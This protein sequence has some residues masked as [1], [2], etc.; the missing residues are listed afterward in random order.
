[1]EM[2]ANQYRIDGMAGSG[3]FGDVYRGYDI[4]MDRPVAI[5]DVIDMSEKEAAVIKALDHKGLPRLYDIIRTDGHIYMVMEWIEGMDLQKVIET[6]GALSED[7]AVNIGME[8]LDILQYL[9]SRKP[10]IIYQDLKPANIMLKPDGHI[11]LVDFGTALVMTYGDEAMRIAGTIGY[12]A[13]EQR[14]MGGM[15]DV[16]EKSDIYS[17]G[18]VMYS[19]VTGQMLNKP[20]YGMKKLRQVCPNLSFGLQLIIQKATRRNRDERYSGVSELISAMTNSYLADMVY[21]VILVF[22]MCL[23][24]GPFVLAWVYCIREGLFS[25]LQVHLKL[26]RNIWVSAPIN[27]PEDCL[28]HVIGMKEILK[29]GIDKDYADN[30]L[31]QVG[32][33]LTGAGWMFISLRKVAF[34][35]YIRVNRSI[36]LSQ[37]RHDILW[38]VALM[39]GIVFGYG[40][41]MSEVSV[42]YAAEKDTP[43][44]PVSIIDENG[45]KLLIDYSDSYCPDEEL[46]LLLN[47][48]V[49]KE[50]G[51]KELTL[52]LRNCSNENVYSRVLYLE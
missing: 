52:T 45:E 21:K 9:H 20:P 44:L 4:R 47:G 16:N 46:M 48:M 40:L 23:C 50:D 31:G 32:A 7:K 17:W 43:A 38:A 11:K 5:K 12:G 41:S 39:V 49:M 26:L 29:V 14:G 28:Q 2:I 24:V 35:K 6:K 42:S 25:Y 37:K 27:T 22:L 8:L 1:M 18:A 13:P 3:G 51:S 36:F 10:M 30:L 34:K 19:M 33:L 15:T